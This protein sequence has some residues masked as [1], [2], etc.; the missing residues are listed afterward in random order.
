MKSMEEEP[1]EDDTM[2]NPISVDRERDELER[3]N[4]SIIKD[5]GWRVS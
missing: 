2:S 1:C 5:V 4:N 3:K